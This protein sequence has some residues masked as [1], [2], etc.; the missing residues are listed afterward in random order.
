M[1]TIFVP[2]GLTYMLHRLVTYEQSSVVWLQI[3]WLIVQRLDEAQLS[4]DKRQTIS[5]FGNGVQST[6]ILF[7]EQALEMLKVFCW[8]ISQQNIF[9]PWYLFILWQLIYNYEMGGKHLRLDWN[10]IVC[11][12]DCL[13]PMTTKWS[14]TQIP[15]S[16][17]YQPSHSCCCSPYISYV[18]WWENLHKHQ[19]LSFEGIFS[20]ILVTC[21]FDSIVVL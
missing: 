11:L 20:K 10:K 21:L 17:W 16:S 2:L 4:N 19:G 13:D 14:E 15:W 5:N 8:V 1:F 6:V 18:S 7:L 9:K 12:F 3:I